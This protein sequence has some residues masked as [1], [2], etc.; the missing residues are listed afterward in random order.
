VID[1]ELRCGTGDTL[2]L[3]SGAGGAA[4]ELAGL[5]CVLDGDPR[6]VA[7][8]PVPSTDDAGE[9]PSVEAMATAAVAL[10]RS[11]QPHGPYRLLG[12]SLGGIVALETGRLLE[13]A[14]EVVSFLGLVDALFDQRYWPRRLFLRASARRAGV[15]AKGMVGKPPAQAW[16]ELRDRT[17]RLAAR[18]SHRVASQDGEVDEAGMTV[19]EANLAVMARWQPRVFEGELVL[20]AAEETDFGCDLADLWRP[21]L[22]GM[23][24]R[25]VPGNHLDLV[26]EPA[27]IERLAQAVDEELRAAASPRLRALVAAT[28]RWS[29]AARLAA[30]LH[31]SGCDVQ[32]V[33]P[34][35][36]A[37]H[38]ISAVGRSYVL[39]LVNAVGSLRRAI[40]ASNPD[41]IIPFDDRTR[42]VMHR[43]HAAADPATEEG[44][45][46]RAR[47]E[48]SLGPSEL[49]SCLYSRVAI[50]DIAAECGVR[51]PPTGAVR[52]AEDI[53]T[54]LDRHPGPAVLK[55][56]GSWGGRGT[57]VIRTA[58]DACK[59]W[60]QLSRP[61][62]LARCVKRVLVERDPWPL[63]ARLTGYRP[64]VSIQAYVE[65]VPGNAA[66][67]SLDGELLG[68]VQA[69]VVQTNG[70]TGPSTVLRI[71]E[72]PEM[73][74]A[75]R[76][77][78]ERLHASGLVG[79]DFILETETGRA[80]LIEL[81]PRA[82]PTSHLISAEGIDLLTSLRSALGYAGPAP[83]VAA[84]PDG[85]VALFPEELRRVP[86]STLL[87][88]AHHDVPWHAP[89]LVAH[90]IADLHTAGADDVRARLA[91]VARG[92]PA[93]PCRPQLATHHDGNGNA[94]HRRN[95]HDGHLPEPLLPSEIAGGSVGLD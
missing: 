21:W 80:H 65:G 42:R 7:L 51:C 34:R 16:H 15:H 35:G 31:A 73:L 93:S 59:A 24:V 52:S 19:Q 66:V 90:A 71:V 86:A 50:M 58:A 12:Y 33:A 49:Y 29:G 23:K 8:V 36:S 78:V 9:A 89:D 57:R 13:E 48:R 62:G 88:G 95:G 26:Q 61:P 94:S 76:T 25:P 53:T 6:V 20:F 55:T 54:W 40:E 60:R 1:D 32:A 74:A 83:R 64:R 10:M 22:P 82:T 69:E 41:V 63:R 81:N 70:P 14:G 72:H 17:E 79:L 2:F 87:D 18:L 37:L 75:A 30:D 44:A 85:L 38:E 47:I 43:I 39:G 68:A 11:H 77:M 4:D 3:I 91:D 56:D 67:A 27:G 46:L 28:F 45:R 5:A 84:Y 92:T